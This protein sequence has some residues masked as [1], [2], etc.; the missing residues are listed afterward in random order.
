MKKRIISLLMHLGTISSLSFVIEMYRK[1]EFKKLIIKFAYQ[2]TKV[3]YAK[4]CK[5]IEKRN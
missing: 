3:S 2:T 1:D 4:S 5:G